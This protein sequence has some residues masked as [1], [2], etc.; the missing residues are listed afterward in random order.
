MDLPLPILNKAN[1]RLCR[2]SA[3]VL[4]STMLPEGCWPEITHQ[5]LLLLQLR[6]GPALHIGHVETASWWDRSW[7]TSFKSGWWI[8]DFSIELTLFSL[9]PV[10]VPKLLNWMTFLLCSGLLT[11][12]FVHIF[13]TMS[14]TVLHLWAQ[15]KVWLLVVLIMR[16][17]FLFHSNE[18]AILKRGCV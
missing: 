11:C 2:C 17:E 1:R 13:K 14:T 6:D 8:I 9:L 5:H 18:L 4:W 12:R 7:V 10:V 16:E 3:R 15:E